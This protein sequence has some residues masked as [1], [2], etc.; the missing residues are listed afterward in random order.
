MRVH[1]VLA[2]G[3][4][5]WVRPVHPA[6]AFLD[7]ERISVTSPLGMALIGARASHVVWVSAPAGVWGCTVLTID[8]SPV[9]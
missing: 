7:D 9:G 5:A 2:D 4:T 3:S 6:E 1:V 8:P